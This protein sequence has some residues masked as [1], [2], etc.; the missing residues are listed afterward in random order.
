M[1]KIS[2]TAKTL[3]AKKNLFGLSQTQLKLVTGGTGVVVN[4]TGDTPSGN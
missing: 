3:P 2:S 4:A 1:S